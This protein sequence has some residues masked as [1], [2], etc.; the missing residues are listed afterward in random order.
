MYATEADRVTQIPKPKS[1]WTD[2]DRK[3]RDGDDKAKA[4][5]SMALGQDISIVVG[6]C[7]S[8]QEVWNELKNLY[9]GNA[10]MKASRVNM[11]NQQ[12][13]SGETIENQI[14]RFVKLVSQMISAS[15]TITN[16]GMNRQLLNS[17]PKNWDADV[18]MIKRTKNLNDVTLTK[19]IAIIKSCEIDISKET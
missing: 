14:R 13:S 8:A 2:D 6:N 7:I 10:D 11:L 12:F 17:L 15:I 1:L 3:I 16:I 4:I 18:A 19:L 5:L 9:E